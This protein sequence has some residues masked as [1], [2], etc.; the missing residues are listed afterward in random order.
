M[1]AQRLQRLQQWLAA[2]LGEPVEIDAARLLTG[3]AIQENWKLDLRVAG[4]PQHWVLRTD[5]PSAVATSHSRA[6]EF[7]LLRA[8]HDAGVRVPAPHLLCADATVIGAAF[9]IVDYVAGTANGRRIVRDPKIAEFGPPLAREL[10]RQLALIHRIAPPREDLA[11]LGAP[12]DNAALA[13]IASYRGYL[14]AMGA[15]QP[16]LEYALRQLELRAPASTEAVLAHSD[17]RSGNYLVADGALSAVLDWEFAQ[18]GDPHEDIGWFCAHC[19]RFGAAAREA[20]GIAARDELL[21]GYAELAERDIDP[22]LVTY[23]EIMAALRWAVIALQ[24]GHRYS[25]GGEDSLELALTGCMPP[26]MAL[27]AL[28]QLPL[29]D[30]AAPGGDLA[31]GVELAPDAPDAPR[32]EAAELLGSARRE[33]LETLLPALPA[34]HKYTT[35]MIANGMAIAARELQAGGA[36]EARELAALRARYAAADCSLDA[37]RRRLVADIRSG[38]GDADGRLRTSFI[39]TAR[40]ALRL[41]NPGYLRD[42]QRWLGGEAGAR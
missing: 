30:G 33:L 32:N 12:P 18:W 35:L 7:A 1:Q 31:G 20:G 41:S 17:F 25:A 8:A 42:V 29:L 37:L 23:W 40:D 28:L 21:A 27:D 5:A 13:R 10:G 6:E 26:Q 24:Q 2:Q 15:P 38:R 16:A 19:W 3:G 34:A 39:E 11:F 22:R 14:D 9:F 4:A 36:G